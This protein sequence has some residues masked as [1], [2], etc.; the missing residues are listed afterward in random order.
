MQL[1]PMKKRV[2]RLAGMAATALVLALIVYN[3]S[4]SPEWRGF[5]WHLAA[6]LLSHARAGYLLLAVLL[7]YISIAIR[8][9]R[10]KFF[11]R[12]VKT[13]PVWNLFVAQIYGFASI[14]LIGRPGEIVRPA[15][16]ANREAVSF[17]SQLAIL[18]LERV[19][20]AIAMGIIFALALH[21]T[22]V[23]LTG[24]GA[25]ALLHR[26]R[27]ASVIVLLVT[28]AL[29]AGM[30]VFRLSA[31][32]VT[33]FVERRFRFLP[34]RFR[35]SPGRVLRS[36]AAGLG[37]IRSWRDLT[38]SVACTILLWTLNVTMFWVSFHSLGG[39]LLSVSWWGAA[40]AS[41]LGGIG[42]ALQLPG[43]GGG[44]Q[45]AIIESLKRILGVA[46]EAAVGGGLLIWAVLMLPVV[47]LGLAL[48]PFQRVSFRRLEA[49]ADGEAQ[50]AGAGPV[51]P[52]MKD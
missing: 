5:D 22:A 51:V 37:A 2:H 11:L 32:A 36:L 52:Q 28:A 9:L 12:P 17:T 29:V 20:D 10:W 30:V 43:V 47:G 48:L 3:V 31:E 21:F 34:A 40:I 45:I 26:M 16:I 41:F 8:A 38:A 1:T 49:V 24:L 50:G 33:E 42:L 25:G 6:N 39:E 4:R 7:V 15:Y 46:P 18:I 14:F 44:I 27:Q 35:S 19:Y 13:A 23:R